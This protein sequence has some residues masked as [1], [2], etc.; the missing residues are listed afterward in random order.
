MKWN[1]KLFP[2]LLMIFSG[3][4]HAGITIGGTRVIYPSEQSEVQITLKNKDSDQRY[5]VQSWVSNIDNSKAPFVVTPPVY[6]LE[7]SRQTLLHVVYTG[8]KEALPKDRETV[9]MLNVKSVSAIP[10]S[11]RTSNTLQL[12]VKNKIKLFYRPHTLNNHAAQTAWT[13]LQ[14]KKLGNQL[15]VKNPTPFYVSFGQLSI[16]DKALTPARNKNESTALTMMVAPF[17]EQFFD[18][19]ANIKGQ[20]TW[21]AITDFGAETEPRKQNL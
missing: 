11:L 7:E 2:L 6:K 18:I 19:P 15:V 21:S 17:S 3:L 1:F 13:E 4:S 9:F 16:A 20:L 5:L 8:N 14:F 10:E 12:A